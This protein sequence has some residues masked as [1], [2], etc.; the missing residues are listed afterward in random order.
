MRPPSERAKRDVNMNMNVKE[1]MTQ[2]TSLLLL[3]YQLIYDYGIFLIILNVLG[4]VG[5]RTLTGNTQTQFNS[6][7]VIIIC[8]SYNS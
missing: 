4:D 2:K 3:L 1:V 7:F 6:E 8:R 5:M